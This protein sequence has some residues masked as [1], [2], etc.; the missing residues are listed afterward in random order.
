MLFSATSSP[1]TTHD[2][3]YYLSA[4]LANFIRPGLTFAVKSAKV[5]SDGT[6]SVDF[7]VTD[8]KGL[9]LDRA[10]VNTAGAI[11]TSFVIAYIPAGQEQFVSY[12]TRTDTGPRRHGSSH[13]GH[14]RLRRHLHH[15]ADGEYVY[16]LRQQAAE[17]AS[18]RR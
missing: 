13:P 5:A 8:P 3:A 17:P 11:S 12:I 4:S 2:K 15:V 1:F 7:T 6:L 10:G 16:T 18:T 14:R 9:G